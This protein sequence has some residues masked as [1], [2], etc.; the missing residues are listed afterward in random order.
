MFFFC[1]LLYGDDSD[2]PAAVELGLLR[3]GGLY[4]E[5]FGNRF[6]LPVN[7]AVVDLCR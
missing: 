1:C 2:F 3:A 4:A 5:R 6:D 7:L